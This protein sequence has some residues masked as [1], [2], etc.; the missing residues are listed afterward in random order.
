M[1]TATVRC[2]LAQYKHDVRSRFRPVR[3]RAGQRLVE[4]ICGRYYRPVDPTVASIREGLAAWLGRWEQS[5]Y[6]I[7]GDTAPSGAGPTFDLLGHVYGLQKA[8][9]LADN[10][11]GTLAGIGV[12]LYRLRASRDLKPD[13]QGPAPLGARAAWRELARDGRSWRRFPSG[14]PPL[15]LLI[16]EALRGER[17]E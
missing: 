7:Q 6:P 2:G 5:L 16:V 9:E 1:T 10:D 8:L 4:R 3:R 11:P 13:G 17:V 14:G 12:E 15:S